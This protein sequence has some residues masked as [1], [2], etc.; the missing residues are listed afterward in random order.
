MPTVTRRHPFRLNKIDP[1]VLVVTT[2][3]PRRHRQ[4]PSAASP[5]PSPAPSHSFLHREVIMSTSREIV[6]TLRRLQLLSPI[7][8]EFQLM[9]Q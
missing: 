3:L 2:S 6:H 7:C 8:S 4:R 5:L 9:P 1:S